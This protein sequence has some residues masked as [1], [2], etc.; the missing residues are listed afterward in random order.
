MAVNQ[1]FNQTTFTS[2]QN[3]VEDLVIESIQIH[4]QDFYYI[5]RTEVNADTIF[6]EASLS[7]FNTAHLIEMHIE[8]SE[9]F[10][11]EGDFLSK[12][13]LEVRDQLNV[14]VSKK[15]FAEATN[16]PL[17]LSGDLIY[18][19][20]VDRCFEI[21][22]VEDEIPFYQLGKMYVFRLATELFEYSHESFDTGVAEI[23]DIGSE[24]T[25]FSVDLTFGS[26]TGDFAVGET[27]YQGSTLADAVATG[28]VI[29]WNSGT[30]VLRVGSLTGTFSQ[31]TNTVGSTSSAEY[32]LGATQQIT[33][34]ETTDNAT[35]NSSDFSGTTDSVIDF[36]V[37]NPFSESY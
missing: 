31:N 32:L 28:E 35:D 10:G 29:S 16:K 30:K 24:I 14:I 2:E 23:D 8:D 1:Y 17:P 26:G 6:N 37:T 18:F 12:F 27:I 11:G 25:S 34:I 19:P 15:R 5:E 21:Q 36:S 20:L 9:G 13:G 7:E 33:Y 22:F 3:L 4:G